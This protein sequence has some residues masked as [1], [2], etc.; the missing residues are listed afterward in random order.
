MNLTPQALL[1]ATR[2]TLTDPASA[3]RRVMA[4]N[5]TEAEGFMALGITATAATLLTAAMQGIMGP[6]VD[7][8]MQGLFDRP[9]LLAISQFLVMAAG[10]YLMWRLGRACGG[11]GTLAQAL[12]LVAWLEVVLIILQIIEVLVILL[13]PFLTVLVSL[14]S[15][16]VFFYLFTHFTA[17]LNGFTS[18]TRTFFAILGTFV[19]VL[20][21][22]SVLL[23]LFIPVPHV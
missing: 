19:V 5:L 10:A 1:V 15:V 6:V 11:T 17:A 3:A 14:G 16:V 8:A 20:L 12:V 4:L 7:P 22:V 23:V 13:L 9:F 21:L 2:H 18:L